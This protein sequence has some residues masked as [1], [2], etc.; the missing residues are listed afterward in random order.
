[1][2]DVS[3]APRNSDV[4]A[5]ILGT[6]AASAFGQTGNGSG[7]RSFA[8]A[9]AGIVLEA[10]DNP[11]I[12]EL[13][14][15][16]PPVAD[17]TQAPAHCDTTAALGAQSLTVPP[18][19]AQDQPPPV[20]FNSDIDH[21]RCDAHPVVRGVREHPYGNYDAAITAAPGTPE[22]GDPSAVPVSDP[23][24]RFGSGQEASLRTST[25][26]G[27]G[28]ST[29]PAES[30]Q[31]WTQAP[32]ETIDVPAVEHLPLPPP[33]RT[34]LGGGVLVEESVLPS[35]G[36]VREMHSG[37]RAKAN[38]PSFAESEEPAGTGAAVQIRATA[39]G[40][41][42]TITAGGQAGF[43]RGNARAPFDSNPEPNFAPVPGTG[44]SSEHTEK[45]PAAS[46][47]SLLFPSTPLRTSDAQ[48]PPTARTSVD[49][50]QTVLNAEPRAPVAPAS[51]TDGAG[52]TEAR[53]R[54][55]HELQQRIID[56]MVREVRLSRFPE[57]SE[58]VVRL[59]PPELGSLRVQLIQ[60]G[61]G[62]TG[63][64]M[65]STDNVRN[66]IQASLPALMDALSTAGLKVESVS[67]A[68]NPTMFSFEHSTGFGNPAHSGASSGQAGGAEYRSS[69]PK[70]LFADMAA[71][72]SVTDQATGYS[73]LA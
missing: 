15:S 44:F 67:V 37:P 27:R 49:E 18:I 24:L 38:Q 71:M 62:L 68:S 40:D 6:D 33:F 16:E 51:Q 19:A 58:L 46:A 45:S 34:G 41:A 69:E 28:E 3:V 11:Q 20:N 64:I 29:V 35:Q 47:Q 57:R 36:M 5:S 8:A 55:D 1:M 22:L 4:P 53:P 9:L 10:G 48:E 32:Q 73:W 21:G 66:L 7:G 13:E 50:R 12:K 61:S 43:G 17:H 72:E 54:F 60:S 31:I 25:G 30:P 39:V 52:H 56:Q 59:T 2:I 26:L 65:T 14:A 42:Q 70:E 63:Q 23:S